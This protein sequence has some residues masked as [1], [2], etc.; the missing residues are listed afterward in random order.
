MTATTNSDQKQIVDQ[1]VGK[2]R[3]WLLQQMPPGCEYMDPL[4]ERLDGF[5]FSL[6]VELEGAGGLPQMQLTPKADHKVNLVDHYMHDTW[7]D[8]DQ[9]GNRFVRE[10]LT[11]IAHVLAETKK[12]DVSR[13]EAMGRLGVAVCQTIEQGYELR[14]EWYDDDV[15][16]GTSDDLAPGLADAFAAAWDS[17]SM[18]DGRSDG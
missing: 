14:A 5:V 3:Y 7:P 15:F 18:W 9:A 8:V 6:F 1:L 4:P 17:R 12:L 11:A 10:F 13:A 2:A 16:T